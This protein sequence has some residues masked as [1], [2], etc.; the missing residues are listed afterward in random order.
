MIN[1][2]LNRHKD[3]VKFE[4]IRTPNDIITELQLIKSHIQ[5]HF[6]QW[7]AYR[8]INQQVFN[9]HWSEKYLP[10]QNVDSTWYNKA[11]NEI[12]LEEVSQTLS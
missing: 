11:F 5:Q 7:T 3:P 4:N 9:S 2:I 6:D 12:T 8:P 1:S 10:K